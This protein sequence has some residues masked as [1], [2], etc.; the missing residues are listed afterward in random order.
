MISFPL[1]GVWLLRGLPVAALPKCRLSVLLCQLARSF[2]GVN[3][4]H[5]TISS[6]CLLKNFRFEACP[7]PE[8]C[9]IFAHRLGSAKKG[10]HY[11]F[12]RGLF[13]LMYWLLLLWF[14]LCPR[15]NEDVNLPSVSSQISGPLFSMHLGWLSFLNCWGMKLSRVAAMSSSAF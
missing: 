4:S 6:T 1:S 8:F 11:G 15:C 9:G 7:M 10:F 5:F 12:E 3:V 2:Q 13:G 14:R